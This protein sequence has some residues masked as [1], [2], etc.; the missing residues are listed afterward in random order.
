MGGYGLSKFKATI[1][2]EC[3]MRGL[4]LRKNNIQ[5]GDETTLQKF[6]KED[7]GQNYFVGEIFA[8]SHDL[9]PNSQRNYF[10]EN[11]SRLVFEQ[12]IRLFFKELQRVYYEGS[13]INSAFDKIDTFSTKENDF[14][15]KQQRGDYVSD[16]HFLNDKKS[17]DKARQDSIKAQVE[18]ERKK[19]QAENSPC[20]IT[21]QI[22]KRIENTRTQTEI[23]SVPVDENEFEINKHKKTYQNQP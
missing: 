23:I 22:I 7:R 18:I 14:K 15:I 17:L 8:V 20:S 6:F 16:E 3:L 12:E 1:S 5:I 10:N 11:Y 21:G 19:I 4:R 2:R 9:I 13:A